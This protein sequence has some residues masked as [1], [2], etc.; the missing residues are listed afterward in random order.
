LASRAAKGL[1][2]ADKLEAAADEARSAASAFPLTFWI[3]VFCAVVILGLY[4]GLTANRLIKA[5]EPGEEGAKA[6]A[7]L[8]L[9]HAQS[10]LTRLEMSSQPAAT[11][12]VAN[13]DEPQDALDQAM[14]YAHPTAVGGAI[15]GSGARILAV[16][17]RA[18]DADW[19]KVAA[20]ANAAGLGEWV[21]APPLTAS[22]T[23][24]T[25][26]SA[27]RNAQ[28]R[29]TYVATPVETPQGRL[30]LILAAD[31]RGL[32]SPYAGR[33]ALLSGRNGVIVAASGLAPPYSELAALGLAPSAVHGVVSHGGDVEATLEAGREAKLVMAASAEA[34][35][36]AGVEAPSAASR[37]RSQIANIFSLVAP[38]LIG[39]ILIVLM[40]AQARRS[41]QT[42][43]LR[44]ERERK[45]RMA[46]EAARCGIWEWRLRDE[47]V[48]M[49]DMTGLMM[50]WGGGGVV[51]TDEFVARIAPDHQGMVRRALQGA[52]TFGALDVTF[53]VPRPSGGFAWLDARGQA[54]GDPDIKGYTSLIGVALDVTEERVAEQ[55]VLAAERRLHDAIDSVSEAFVL[56]DRRGRL[57]MCNG[58]F[59]SFFLL[60]PHVVEP[61]AKRSAVHQLVN[62]AIRRE[63]TP[64]TSAPGTREV[65][66]VDGRWL[67][68][69]ER[70]TAEGGLVMT[71][72]DVTAIKS[73][74]EARRLN[75]EALQ[76]AV[77]RLK[78]S[79]SK[80]T[81]LA[82]KYQEEKMRA[83][84]A[85]TAKSGFLANMSHEL[86]T[87]LNAIN[88]FSEIMVHEMFGPLGDRR[89]KEYAQDILGS[90]QHL[91]ALIN[92]ILDMS[93]I[94]AG[95]MSLSLDWLQIDDVVSDVARLMRNRA[96]AANLVLAT[97]VPPGLPEIEADYRAVKQI[98]LNLISNA[99]KFTPAGGRID[100]KV[101]SLGEET[102]DHRLQIQ[103]CDTGIGIS[104]DDIGRLAKPFE[105][106]ETQHAKAQ[107]GSGLG[108]AL[109]KALVEM[110]GGVFE[111]ES[112]PGLGTTV[113]FTLPVKRN[114]RGKVAAVARAVA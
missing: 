111:L 65:E 71:A 79:Q 16:A 77:T 15:V 94:E 78:E 29:W 13:P 24:S 82:H 7:E 75:E 8:L 69:S 64:S 31:L 93:K 23:S 37:R 99:V 67:Q 85:N 102:P 68:I 55:R 76:Q 6:G 86:R 25:T 56:W 95:K 50:G 35:L 84:S 21:G 39:A 27:R 48:L 9:S 43:A 114:S 4:T 91:L 5:A 45:F 106:I 81:E 3:A 41:A 58:A 59:R 28:G 62:L 30:V 61:G 2:G 11:L 98:L 107:A 57:L 54:F 101:W 100:V 53:C 1:R 88:G 96:D 40:V 66:M 63:A 18:T 74:E 10:A 80:L 70:R 87:P 83:E 103:V 109:T 44:N 73:Q 42:A 12:L 33:V 14:R 52:L 22:T 32:V 90:G 104:Q 108:L 38:T 47:Q 97:S 46:V 105:Q 92:D 72:A 34:P 19:L 17:G 112:E 60:E 26:A 49:S 36:I 51:S 113:S 110:H 89:Y 20:A